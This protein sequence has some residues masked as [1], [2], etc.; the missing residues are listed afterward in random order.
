MSQIPQNMLFTEEHEYLAPTDKEGVYAV[1][2]TA[3]AQAE[4]GDVVFVELPE[5]GGRFDKGAT[6]GTVEAVKA[7][8]DLYCPV[9]GE[10]VEVND[11]LDA[12][13]ALVN[14]DPYGDG[15]MIRLRVN[16]PAELDSLLGPDEYRQHIGES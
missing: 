1:G 7:V 13:P 6:F 11:R 4:L 2:I 16:D 15:W 3:Y 5:P 14:T 9:G 10:V 8:S 12:D